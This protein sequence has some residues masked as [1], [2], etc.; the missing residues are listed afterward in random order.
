MVFSFGC[1]RSSWARATGAAHD[2]DMRVPDMASAIE[3]KIDFEI[4]IV[5]ADGT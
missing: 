3:A 4:E 2:A 5:L 1:L